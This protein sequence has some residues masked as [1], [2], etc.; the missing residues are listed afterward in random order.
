[1]PAQSIV[2]L[3]DMRQSPRESLSG[4]DYPY[5]NLNYTENNT[6]FHPYYLVITVYYNYRRLP[7]K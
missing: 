6:K 3:A 5:S 4:P 2:L 7:P 1:M